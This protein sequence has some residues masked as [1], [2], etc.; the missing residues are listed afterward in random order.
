MHTFW[1]TTKY[2]YKRDTMGAVLVFANTAKAT[3]SM[4]LARRPLPA[5]PRNP[6]FRKRS[7]EV[8]LR[9]KAGFQVSARESIQSSVMPQSLPM[10]LA[11]P[12]SVDFPFARLR[13]AHR[14][15]GAR[16]SPAFVMRLTISA[17]YRWFAAMTHLRVH[18]LS[19]WV[20]GRASTYKA[21]V[22]FS[23]KHLVLLQINA[24]GHGTEGAIRVHVMHCT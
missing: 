4:H 9:P 7:V 10:H 1:R 21:V 3:V 13:T 2:Q 17:C 11:V 19:R 15:L 20:I 24:S 12:Q 6:F 23:T 22:V 5:L 18:D 16:Q 8:D 14:V